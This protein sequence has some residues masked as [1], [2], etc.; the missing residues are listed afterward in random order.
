VLELAGKWLPRH[1]DRQRLTRTL[2]DF[3]LVAASL[4]VLLLM[5]DGPRLAPIALPLMAL[6]WVSRLWRLRRLS[7]PT[8]LGWPLLL[9]ALTGGVGVW[10][11]YDRTIAWPL[12]WLIL[13]GVGLCF[14]LA[15]SRGRTGGLPGRD[16]LQWFCLGLCVFGALLGAYFVT[17]RTGAP[18][19]E[20]F[21]GIARLGAWLVAHSPQVPGPDL[22]ANLLG[23]VLAVIWPINLA[24][25]A[26]GATDLRK[27]KSS[28]EPVTSPT[29]SCSRPSRQRCGL[30]AALLA[31][32]VLTFA[33]IMS[34]SRGAWIGL[35]VGGGLAS[36][37]SLWRWC[38][39]RLSTWH[40]AV[41]AGLAAVAISV[42]LVWLA[43]SGAAPQVYAGRLGAWAANGLAEIAGLGR[44]WIYS[45][46]LSLVRDY[47]FTG[48]GLGS[49]WMVFSTY[50]LLTHVGFTSHA[51]N[52]FLQLAT[53]Q[54]VFGLLSFL[55]LAA[56]AMR[57]ARPPKSS[58]VNGESRT[59]GRQQSTGINQAARW[60]ILVML[61][62]GL[63]DAPLVTGRMLPVLFVPFGLA[64]MSVPVD[65]PAGPRV[66]DPKPSARRRRWL[67]GL[68]LAA[69]V[70]VTALLWRGPLLSSLFSN[71]GTVHQTWAEL[72]LYEWPKWPIQD[73]VRRE[74][75]LSRPVAELQ[76]ALA[77]DSA[78][79]SANRRLGMIELS[80]GEYDEALSHLTRA[81]AAEPRS[82]TT[83]QLLGE[84]LIANGQLRAGRELW[85][86]VENRQGQLDLRASWYGHIGDE[87]RA[88]WMR[89]AADGR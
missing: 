21:A 42:G 84:A 25:V 10:A 11:A 40:I 83:R 17:Q 53:Q 24:L 77:H 69:G 32:I 34:G 67:A 63:V 30:L 1:E 71:L 55:W 80:L 47:P 52:L 88:A 16:R 72:S 70:L 26:T 66:S 31:F 82:E 36:L 62:H 33:L 35:G 9:F 78:N 44:I 85:S 60:S 64:V 79:G 7:L 68:S 74:V 58:A 89:E 38:K 29:R 14:A 20:N 45:R 54:G 28:G 46:G 76:R 86:T 12:F 2:V 81:L 23:A 57:Y 6:P 13:G 48:S 65:N 27:A 75:D 4:A 43:R 19:T 87:Q 50:A 15:N 22:N 73:A 37:G 5:A 49:F 8:P 39:G 18:E 51:H 59:G 61:V 3:E 56:A 41:L